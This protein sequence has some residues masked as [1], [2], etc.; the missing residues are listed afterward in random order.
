[1]RVIPVIDLMAGQ[2]VRAV[3]GRRSEYRLIQSRLVADAYPSTIAEAL[4]A[5][6][7]F[8]TVYIA[9]LD[10]IMGGRR[11]ERC[12]EL[13]AEAGL[14][15]WLDAGVSSKS[16]ATVVLQALRRFAVDP[17]IIVGLESL[18]APE[19]LIELS[20]FLGRDTLAF[21]LDLDRGQAMTRIE[22]WNHQP[23]IEIVR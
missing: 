23:P 21:S 9:D 1:M 20:A 10:V 5:K 16:S 15:L 17:T 18:E 12:W 22:K 3:A 2:V 4:V 11:N 19:F 13:I 8:D 14:K 7:H 6:Y